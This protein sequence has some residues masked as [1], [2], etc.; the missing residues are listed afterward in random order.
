MHTN[1]IAQPQTA[2]QQYITT[3][4]TTAASQNPVPHHDRPQ[5]NVSDA[6]IHSHPQSFPQNHGPEHQQPQVSTGIQNPPSRRDIIHPLPLEPIPPNVHSGY[7]PPINNEISP[8]AFYRLHKQRRLLNNLRDPRLRAILPELREA[9]D[10]MYRAQVK[11]GDEMRLHFFLENERTIGYITDPMLSV[12]SSL[13]SL[14]TFFSPTFVANTDLQKSFIREMV[15]IFPKFRVLQ[16]RQPPID[17]YVMQRLSGDSFHVTA[18]SQT[19][20]L[21]N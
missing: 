13:M 19:L 10:A 6:P 15:H 9:V 20:K 21:Q 4:P 14:Y 3:Q 5:H 18:P 1:A 11:G 16:K 12:H 17:Y 2:V 7:A 8:E